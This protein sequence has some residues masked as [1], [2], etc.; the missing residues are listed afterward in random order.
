M[1]SPLKALLFLIFVLI[2][3]AID[4]NFIYPKIVG[5]SVGLPG[6]LVL[7]A[8]IL[9][10]NIGGILGVL[11]GVPTAS[12]IYALVVDWLK[13]RNIDNENTNV[14]TESATDTDSNTKIETVS[15]KTEG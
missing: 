3:Q 1:E 12:A 8:V 14:E 7:I 5:K 11:L 15:E 4:N 13:N 2:L 6:M 10:G 9:G